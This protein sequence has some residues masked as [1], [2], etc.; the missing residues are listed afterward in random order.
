MILSLGRTPRANALVAAEQ[1]RQP[2]PAF[3]LEVAFCPVCALVQLT[4][5]VPPESLFPE[6]AYQSSMSETFARSASA[7]AE[8][9]MATRA[10]TADSFVVEIGSND[11]CLLQNYANSGVPVL[12][13]DPAVEIAAIATSRG[14]PTLCTFFNPR[15]ARD[16]AAERGRADVIH[17]NNVLAHIPDLNGAAAGVAELLKPGGVAVI[18]VPY[19]RD[20]VEHVE[21]DTIYHEHVFYFSLTSASRLFERHGLAVTDV[22]RLPIHGGTLRLFV[23]PA[24][25]ASPSAAVQT[26]FTDERA[27]GLDR[28][29]FYEDFA[30]AVATV[31]RSLTAQLTALRADGKRIAAYG[32]SAKGATLLNY[33]GIGTELLEF[34]VDRNPLKQGRFMPGVHIPIVAV[35][36]VLTEMPDYLLL[37]TWN[38]AD[39]IM[40][41]Q[42]EYSARGGKF[43][44]P[45]GDATPVQVPLQS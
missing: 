27:A 12:G 7:I 22:E 29:G 28:A 16:L 30:R 25:A 43:I 44:L 39:E 45:L 37:L 32:A 18:E 10:L 24:G 14:I 38:F 41:Q 2:E 35:D 20:L 17:A 5:I 1:L 36:R 42:A 6:Y 26:L 3:P 31:K 19:V 4:E 23:T 33:C 8:R 13:I 11:G 21:F 34:V 40:T 15:V 9:L